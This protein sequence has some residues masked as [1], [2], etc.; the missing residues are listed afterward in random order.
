MMRALPTRRLAAAAALLAAAF[1]VALVFTRDD[2]YTIEARFQNAGQL[3][4]GGVVAVAGRKVGTISDISLTDD[5]QAAIRLSIVDRGV[6]LREGTRATIRAVGQAGLANRFVDLA[7]GPT[8]APKLPDGAVLSTQQTTSIVSIDALLGSFGPKRRVKFQ[9]LITNAEDIYAG[10]GARFFNQMLGRLDPALT[11]LNGLT[12]DLAG[13]RADIGRLVATASAASTAIAN[14]RR[15]LTAAVANTATSLGAIASERNALAD[16]LQRAPAVLRQARGTLAGAGTAL[17]AL[18]PALRDV[19]P[20]AAPLREFLRRT[21][22]TLPPTRRVVGQLRGQLP[23]VNQ[24]LRGLRPLESRAVSALRSTAKAL[25]TSKHIVRGV[26]FY[27]ADLII[28]VFNGVAGVAAANHNKWGHYA[29]IEFTQPP[30]SFVAGS[31]SGL[32]TAQPLVPGLFDLRTRLLRRC[33][34]GNTPPAIDGSSP[35][36]PD[37]SLCTPEHSTPASVNDPPELGG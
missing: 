4:K 22:N 7:P 34:G 35:W 1:A 21:T 10:S 17:T 18:R 15:D 37:A 28:G 23:A 32:L 25:T 2:T 36:V 24:S 6:D 16:T 27:G 29:H 13:D 31:L 8:S 26:R 33:P 12:A 9:E 30:Q 11:E 14:R 5:G 20:T 3:V 19:R